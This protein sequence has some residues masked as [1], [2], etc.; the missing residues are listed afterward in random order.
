MSQKMTQK[1]SQK[2]TQKV[3]QKMTQKV[4]QKMTQ[5][6]SHNTRACPI[7]TCSIRLFD[8]PLN[9][10]LPSENRRAPAETFTKKSLQ[11]F[12]SGSSCKCLEI[13]EW[14]NRI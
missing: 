10:F 11:Y 5:K 8:E 6:V 12:Y 13:I 1:V 3:S 4:S 14:L 2:M 9:I 7:V